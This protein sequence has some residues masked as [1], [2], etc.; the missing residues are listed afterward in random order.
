MSINTPIPIEP[1]Y[2]D[3]D[4][5]GENEGLLSKWC[6]CIIV[7]LLI[8]GITRVKKNDKRIIRR[9]FTK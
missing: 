6:K 7:F 2:D 8:K 1:H 9:L 3:G 5:T 4:E